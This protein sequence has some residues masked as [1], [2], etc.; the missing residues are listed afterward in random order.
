MERNTK[1]LGKFTTLYDDPTIDLMQIHFLIMWYYTEFD[2]PHGKK[3]LHYRHKNI[4]VKGQWIESWWPTSDNQFVYIIE[5]DIVVSKY[6][7]KIVKQD[8]I[9]YYYESNDDSLFGI[10]TQKLT[11]ALGIFKLEYNLTIR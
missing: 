11:N 1:L 10:S 5:D 9:K 3:L 6:W 2:W 4:G 7:Y 8:I